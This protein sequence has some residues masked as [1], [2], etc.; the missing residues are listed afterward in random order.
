MTKITLM[1]KTEVQEDYKS[2]HMWRD[3]CTCDSDTSIICYSTDKQFYFE[4]IVSILI[5]L[6]RHVGSLFHNTKSDYNKT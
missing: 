1:T 2:S 3:Q 5:T 6:Y 4:I